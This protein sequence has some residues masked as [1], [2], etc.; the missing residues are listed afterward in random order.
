MLV[1]T[2]GPREAEEWPNLQTL[3]LKPP[4]R[5]LP[6]QASAGGFSRVPPRQVS[7]QLFISTHHLSEG[8]AVS[9]FSVIIVIQ[10]LNPTSLAEAWPTFQ[11]VDSGANTFTFKVK[12]V[13]TLK[14]MFPFFPFFSAWRKC[15]KTGPRKT[16]PRKEGWGE[17]GP[18]L[19][20]SRDDVESNEELKT[21]SL[22]SFLSLP[23]SPPQSNSS[24]KIKYHCW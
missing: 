4:V 10:R 22:L 1:L 3:A 23:P 24:L 14:G 6:E 11:V 8:N 15:E 17:S 13:A 20:A 12:N 7:C 19:K 2:L 9:N 18:G 5:T 21:A 16:G